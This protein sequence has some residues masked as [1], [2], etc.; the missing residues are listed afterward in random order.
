MDITSSIPDKSLQ[1]LVTSRISNGATRQT[2]IDSKANDLASEEQLEDLAISKIMPPPTSSSSTSSLTIEN[3]MTG[4][5]LSVLS[6]PVLSEDSASSVELKEREV[7]DGYE[8]DVL[9]EKMEPKLL[10][11]LRHQIFTLYRRLFGLVFVA[12]MIIFIIL[13]ARGGANTQHL[14]LITISNLFCAM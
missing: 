7:W 1:P 5:K 14:G 6:T 8:K 11:N 12:N 2:D 9:P 4:E 10:R 13:L 3:S